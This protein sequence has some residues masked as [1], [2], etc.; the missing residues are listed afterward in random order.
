MRSLLIPAT[1][2]RMEGPSIILLFKSSLILFSLSG[3]KIKRF[4]KHVHTSNEE[5]ELVD[6]DI[7]EEV[8]RIT[9]SND[10]PRVL[11]ASKAFWA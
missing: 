10:G 1:F 9:N 5:A 2:M 3:S 8:Q 6:R 4:Q 7:S 11:H